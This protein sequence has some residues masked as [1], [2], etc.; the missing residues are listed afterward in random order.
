[1]VHFGLGPRRWRELFDLCDLGRRQAHEWFHLPGF[2]AFREVVFWQDFAQWRMGRNNLKG[3]GKKI[4]SRMMKRRFPT[5]R[6]AL[7]KFCGQRE[8]NTCGGLYE[9]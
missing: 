2:P 1:M 4:R 5:C 7:N 3:Q 9:K 8:L 6:H